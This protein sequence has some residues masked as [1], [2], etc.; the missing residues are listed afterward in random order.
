MYPLG[1]CVAPVPTGKLDSVAEQ[2]F[3]SASEVVT[4]I[5]AALLFLSPLPLF[6]NFVPSVSNPTAIVDEVP[7]A[8]WPTSTSTST[9]TSKELTAPSTPTPV[10]AS[11]VSAPSM[12]QPEVSSDAD[13]TFADPA[14]P[15]LR[16][17]AFQ[18][19]K[20]A[21]RHG[22]VSRNE[23][24]TWYSLMIATHTGAALDAWSTRRALSGNFGR[25][26]DPLM[27]PFA[28]SKTLYLATQVT[29]LLM[30]II[31]R[32][33]MSSER[34]WLRKLWWAPQ[35]TMATVSFEAAVHNIGV[36]H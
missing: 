8:T 24:I 26:G 15:E 1:Q 9:S 34:T 11:E 6:G 7:I 4:V 22:R 32:R 3:N 20:S 21:I 10:M 27:R 36:V 35:S 29:P 25:E 2:Y 14:A 5:L 23:K 18:P 13:S 31:G 17:F 16:P 33:A 19:V 28:H 30:D 12:A